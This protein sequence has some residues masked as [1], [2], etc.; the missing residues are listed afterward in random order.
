MDAR[1]AAVPPRLGAL[2]VVDADGRRLPIDDALR[3]QTRRRSHGAPRGDDDRHARRDGQRRRGARG[4][5]RHVRRQARAGG[6][7]T[8]RG[9]LEDIAGVFGHALT[10]CYAMTETSALVTILGPADHVFAGDAATVKRTFSAGQPTAMV[11]VKVVDDAGAELPAGSIGELTIFGPKVM[12][13]YWRK[14]AESAAALRDGWL[15]TGDLGYRDENG[16]VFIVDRKKDMIISGG[17]NIYPAEIENVISIHPGVAEVVVIGIPDARWIEAVHAIVV[18]RA[19]AEI[20]ADDILATCRASLGG[21]KVPK[22]VEIR[23]EA[24]PKTGPGK[25]A[26][27]TIRD[28]FWQG[29]DRRI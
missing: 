16:F 17:E 21:F 3:A 13:G 2:C 9:A 14:E 26:R 6:G 15:R 27:K 28:A 1:G 12:R 24:L 22:S 10:H 25:I 18:P 20:A 7:P 19:G 5:H 29:K 4:K 11:E 23:R 8:P